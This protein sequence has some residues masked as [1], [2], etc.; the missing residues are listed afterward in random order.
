MPFLT[1]NAT[2]TKIALN[3]SHFRVFQLNTFCCWNFASINRLRESCKKRK[4]SV[5]LF[6]FKVPKNEGEMRLPLSGISRCKSNR[7]LF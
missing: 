6:F 2:R 3:S 4:R 7:K 5:V 1:T